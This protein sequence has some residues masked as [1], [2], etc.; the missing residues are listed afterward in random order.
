MIRRDLEGKFDTVLEFS[1]WRYS[2]SAVGLMRYFEEEGIDYSTSY[3]EEYTLDGENK[4]KVRN[5]VLCYNTKD[6]LL[7]DEE[8]RERYLDFVEKYF[9]SKMHHL[10]LKALIK[11][12]T[13]SDEDVKSIKDLMKANVI[14]KKV[15]KGIDIDINSDKS[16]K[17]NVLDLMEKNRY[18]LIEETYKNG[19]ATYRNF[20]NQNSLG[21]AEGNVCRLVGY[22]V[23]LPKKKK[24]MAFNWDYDTYVYEDCPEFD[25]IPFG[26][27]KTRDAFFINNNF[28]SKELLKANNNLNNSLYQENDIK[29]DN[30]NARSALFLSSS[31]AAEFINYQV[32]IVVKNR[33][34]DYF[35]TVFVRDLAIDVFKKISDSEDEL[36]VKALS[37][38]CKYGRDSY[39]NITDIVVNSILNMVR[40]DQLIDRLL[41]DKNDHKFLISQLIR[42]NTYLYEKIDGASALEELK[43][44]TSLEKGVYKDMNKGNYFA[45][46]AAN[47]VI[48]KIEKNK[49]IGYRNKLIS[50]L[51]FKDYDRFCTVLLQLSAYSTVSFEFA[52]D[53][54]ENFEENK[55]LAYTFVNA[56]KKNE[57]AKEVNEK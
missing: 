18:S 12:D 50:C 5:D 34:K 24:S 14:M 10:G 25:Y 40:L 47:E 43:K 19:M 53:L 35:E 26:F 36:I 1:D 39:L 16:F 3:E 13:L 56:L 54:F 32:E 41:K 4:S 15:F 44:N 22:Y 31:K 11:N 33:D 57:V 9:K 6:I 21:T 30:K 49:V 38:A 20:C 48:S 7:D 2:A 55:N 17:N 29:D 52:Y 46:K 28:S 8:N 27:S 51:T 37:K 42:I 23:D 45:K